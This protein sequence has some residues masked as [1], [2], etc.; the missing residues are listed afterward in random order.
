ML[1]SDDASGCGGTFFVVAMLDGIDG[2]LINESSRLTCNLSVYATSGKTQL[3][4]VCEF[5]SACTS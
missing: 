3:L 5:V 2:G 1:Q 4:H